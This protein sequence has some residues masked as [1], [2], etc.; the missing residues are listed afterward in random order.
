MVFWDWPA[1]AISGSKGLTS[2]RVHQQVTVRRHHN[3]C[4]N[5]LSCH[6]M[7]FYQH[8]HICYVWAF[9]WENVD[10]EIRRA[11]CQSREMN[12]HR[13]EEKSKEKQNKQD[14]SIIVVI[15][16]AFK[17]IRCIKSINLAYILAVNGPNFRF[18][19]TT[20]NNRR[21]IDQQ[22]TQEMKDDDGTY[23]PACSGMVLLSAVDM[24]GLLYNANPFS[25]LVLSETRS[26]G[27]S[28]RTFWAILRQF[29]ST[30]QSPSL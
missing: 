24:T 25:D 16:K 5:R 26:A 13:R 12:N 8:G 29:S 10:A 7:S 19:R 6:V 23:S 2:L 4:E 17:S 21:E 27:S 9:V 14:S 15:I 20:P 1:A 11:G 28:E 18:T 22:R 3:G 30:W